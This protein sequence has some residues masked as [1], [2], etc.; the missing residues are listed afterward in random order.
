MAEKQKYTDK[1]EMAME[2]AQNMDT[3][4]RLCVIM[5]EIIILATNWIHPKCI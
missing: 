3:E 4:A 5:C 2:M 1:I